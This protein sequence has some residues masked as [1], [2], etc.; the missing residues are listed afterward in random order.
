LFA[1]HYG[2]PTEQAGL[3]GFTVSRRKPNVLALFDTRPYEGG[4]S[5]FGKR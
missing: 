4:I 1:A 2:Q 5:R 3:L